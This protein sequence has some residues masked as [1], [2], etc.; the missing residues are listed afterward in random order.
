[1]TAV[2]FSDIEIVSL[3]CFT[4]R[5]AKAKLKSITFDV[6]R[7][8]LLIDRLK[9]QK[10]Y[11]KTFRALGVCGNWLH[12]PSAEINREIDIAAN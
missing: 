10:L 6:G 2:Q 4:I 7:K 9:G 11:G 12:D 1:M 5:G 8:A 3:A